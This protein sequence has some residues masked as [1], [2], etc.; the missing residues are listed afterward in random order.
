MQF[1]KASLLAAA[2]LLLAVT[3]T[4]AAAITWTCTAKKVT[5]LGV[6]YGTGYTRSASGAGLGLV[7]PRA[8]A[9]ARSACMSATGQICAVVIG[10]CV[11]N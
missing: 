8:R 10:S 7:L 4:P 5:V 11:H 3:A 9:N 2:G 6:P 1:R